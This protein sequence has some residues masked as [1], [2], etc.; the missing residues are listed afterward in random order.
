MVSPTGAHR[1]PAVLIPLASAP[2][3]APAGE[4]AS[5]AVRGIEGD[6]GGSREI[7]SDREIMRCSEPRA[8]AR[9]RVRVRVRGRGRGRVK[10]R[11]RARARVRSTC[12]GA[13]RRP[14]AG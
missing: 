5:V 10:A 7:D 9:V 13:P 14:E 1:V 11:V 8:A 12:N 6:R 2:A 4:A 3:G